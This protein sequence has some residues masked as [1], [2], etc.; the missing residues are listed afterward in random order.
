MCKTRLALLSRERCEVLS[1]WGAKESVDV[2][3]GVGGAVVVLP[4]GGEYEI[5]STQEVLF[6]D[7]YREGG[8]GDV[9]LSSVSSGR[10]AL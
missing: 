10:L 4:D 2:S 5:H 3:V 9:I 6:G 8:I 7:S 1:L